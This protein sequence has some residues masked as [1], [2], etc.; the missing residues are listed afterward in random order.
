MSNRDKDA[1]PKFEMIECGRGGCL[2]VPH[3]PSIDSCDLGI[4]YN[5]HITIH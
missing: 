3:D 4:K 2:V 5:H 1:Q